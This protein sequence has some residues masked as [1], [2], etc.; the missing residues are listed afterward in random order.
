MDAVK[1]VASSWPGGM[2]QNTI[3]IRRSGRVAVV[4]WKIAGFSAGFAVI[5]LKHLRLQDAE[6]NLTELPKNKCS[7]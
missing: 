5:D 3:T 4:T 7:Y 6:L 1:D 2:A